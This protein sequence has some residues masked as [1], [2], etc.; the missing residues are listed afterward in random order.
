MF[1]QIVTRLPEGWRELAT[2]ILAPIA[3][4]PRAQQVL[5]HFFMDSSPF[6]VQVAKYVFLL[7][8]LLLALAA[9]WCTQLSLYTLPFRSNRGRFV[10]LVLL[11][12]WDAA[13]MVWMYWV[14]IVRLAGVVAGW[15]LALASLALR[16][17]V[18]V[19]R[20]VVMAPFALTGSMTRNYFTPG[21]PW[22]A[23]V[24]LIF[25]CVLEAAIFTYTLYPTVTEVL[26]DLAGA[27]ETAKYTTPVLYLFL[28]MLIM[29]S[30]ACVQSLAE[31]AKKREM[32]FLVQMILVELFVMMFEVMFLY[33]ELVDAVTPWLAQATG[34]KVGPVFTLA[35]A[36][37]GWIGVRGMTWFLFGQY[38]TPTLLS[39]ISRQPME[40]EGQGRPSG[41]PAGAQVE[42][43]W[44]AAIADFKRE[45]GW[46]HEHS[47]QMLEY[48]ALPV[49]NLFGGML[50]F[51]M[52]LLLTR[53]AFNLPLR[54][55]KE[56]TDVR[57]ALA[58]M[59]LPPSPRGKE[60]HP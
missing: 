33:R 4:I 45:I 47:E 40:D 44:R 28:L 46:L 54:G 31:A 59:H 53:P 37:F 17:I 12:W 11:A 32:K 48:L 57:D 6:W 49:L 21:V 58:A 56:I 35:L 27:D 26:A 39:F 34:S 60:A 1:D 3:W 38:G 55:L 9:L 42:A 43:P 36:S 18:G 30:F 2:L 52:I 7:M 19:V 15:A 14:G 41:A 23:F 5:G 29:G 25:W 50:N 20:E 13:R 22:I 8:P 16:V 10:S 51:A 24:M